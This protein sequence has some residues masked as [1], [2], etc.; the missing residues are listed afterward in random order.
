M[1]TVDGKE[2]GPFVLHGPL[3]THAY[4]RLGAPDNM[5]MPILRML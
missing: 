5:A 4:L 3:Q 1:V 2:V